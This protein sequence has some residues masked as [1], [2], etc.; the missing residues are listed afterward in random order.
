MLKN[1]FILGQHVKHRDNL[2]SI[3]IV[4]KYIFCFFFPKFKTFETE[5]RKTEQ[6]FDRSSVIIQLS[7]TETS[8]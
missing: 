2:N 8:T 7:T 5:K 4:P 1:I 3:N 6:T